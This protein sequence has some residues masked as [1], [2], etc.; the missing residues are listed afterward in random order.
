MVRTAREHRLSCYGV[1]ITIVVALILY[2]IFG[3]NFFMN[4]FIVFSFIA[5]V[6]ILN[7]W[8]FGQIRAFKEWLRSKKKMKTYQ[9]IKKAPAAESLETSETFELEDNI[10]CPYCGVVQE[11]GTT[12]C[13]KCGQ[14][15]EN[16]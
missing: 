10:T 7:C 2:L 15:I 16:L 1:I 9:Y 13:T 14:K 3:P 6:I 11:K 12:F 8:L 5:F 4:P